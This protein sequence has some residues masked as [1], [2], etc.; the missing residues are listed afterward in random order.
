MTLVEISS[1]FK[2]PKQRIIMLAFKLK[3]ASFILVGCF[4][5]SASAE[6][7]NDK[8]LVE[9][10]FQTG[11]E[12]CNK[13]KSFVLPQ[14]E[15]KYSGRYLLRKYDL[16]QKENFLHLIMTLDQL[17]EDSN[18]SV[19]LILN[20]KTVL[21]GYQ[22]IAEK[23]FETM[24]QLQPMNLDEATNKKLTAD[25]IVATQGA[26]R[27]T[28]TTVIIGG[29]LDGINPCVFSTLIFFM[30][31]LT[32][33]K[34]SGRRLIAV[35]IVYCLACF[36]TYLLLGFGI[37]KII[38][39]LNVIPYLKSFLNWGMMSV[40]LL[41]AALSFRDAWR[42]T[43]SGS[44][45]DKVTLQLPP[46]IKKRIRLIMRHGLKSSYLLSAVFGIGVLVTLLE[47]VCTGQVYVPTLMLLA[48]ESSGVFSR[49]FGLLLLYNVMFILPLLGVFG[50]TYG[51]MSTF[52]AIRLTRNNLRL[53]KILLGI[54]FIALAVLLFLTR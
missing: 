18:Y 46:I 14:F 21:G 24:D 52:Q 44:N 48:S 53:G 12:E 41:I 25:E 8:V 47:S 30:S 49:W 45:P 39:E 9:F 31:L 54:F 11:C 29:L 26:K 35:G 5:F 10:F 28:V 37:L 13:V 32:V 7:V 3:I 16:S 40:L 50:L 6:K 15:E 34:I 33:A 22:A 23:I 2:K 36:L 17:H 20:R 43:T 4:I 38:R 51:G 1:K 42:Y 19:Y 27:M